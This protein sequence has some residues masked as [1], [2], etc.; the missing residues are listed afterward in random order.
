VILL[1]RHAEF[2]EWKNIF[3][4]YRALRKLSEVCESSFGTH[5]EVGLRKSASIVLQ[6]FDSEAGG[7]QGRRAA[8]DSETIENP[9]GNFRRLDNRDDLHAPA[10]TWALQDIEFKGSRHQLCPRVVFPGRLRIIGIRSV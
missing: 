3:W 6:L 2:W 8:D 10:A 7:K 1:S 4:T 9:A 5:V